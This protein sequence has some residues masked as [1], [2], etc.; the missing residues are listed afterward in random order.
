[1]N[2]NTKFLTGLLVGVAAGA[3]IG[4]FLS[5]DKGKEILDDIRSAASDAGEEVKNAFA[6]GKKWAEDVEE[7][8]SFNS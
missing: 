6:K 3:A 1:M 8:A 5:T 2:N 7:K 4:Y